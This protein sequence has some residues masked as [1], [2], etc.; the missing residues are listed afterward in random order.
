MLGSH[1]SHDSFAVLYPGSQTVATAQSSGKPVLVDY[2][3][4]DGR[5]LITGQTLEYAWDASW[6]GGPILE[7]SI[8]DMFFRIFADGF[9]SGDTSAWSSTVP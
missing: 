6:D 7:N 4:G 9:E 1:A 2:S 5:V 8:K 3:Y